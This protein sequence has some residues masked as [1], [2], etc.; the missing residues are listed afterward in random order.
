MTESSKIVRLFLCF[1]LLAQS[2]FPFETDQFN[3]P[4]KPLGDI[5]DEVSDYTEEN[6]RA[7]TVKLNFEIRARLACLENPANK[8]S[9]ENK[10][11]NIKCG[12]PD[13]ER[14]RLDY[15][16]SDE[17]AAR[18]VFKLLGD[19]IVPFTK[20]GTWLETHRFKAQPARYKTGYGKSIYAVVPT[21]Y[22]T[23]SPTVKLYGVE[24]GTD[25]IAHFFQQGYDY[26][27]I[28]NRSL[29]G[30]ATPA[31]AVTKA[32]RWGQMTERTYFGTLVSGVYSN[33]DLC[34][35][36]VG[37]KFYQGLTR[38]IEIGGETRPAILIVKDGFWSVN[39]N[40][41]L[42]RILIKPFLTAHLS[43]ALNPSIY[44]KALRS[45][46]RKTVRKR[47]C[48]QWRARFPK[49]SQ[50]DFARISSDLSEWNGWDYGFKSSENFVTIASVCFD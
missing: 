33:A 31:E 14:A 19:G 17:A 48:A 3:L 45:F 26:Y 2:I 21:N 44:V 7:A 37:L 15:L 6:V 22:F 23:I 34:A 36:L 20:S 8:T 43:E 39:E 12:S 5:G 9:S 32:V 24:F 1:A 10:S 11:K 16:R 4:P 46:V 42:R 40:A 25:K 38:E 28:Y 49:Y 30:G 35:N 47:A 18:A 13:A 29:A 27:K 50:A 41:D